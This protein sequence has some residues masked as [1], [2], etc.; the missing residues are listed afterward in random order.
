MLRRL[1]NL[2]PLSQ[3]WD[4]WHE[5]LQSMTDSRRMLPI[6][7][8]RTCDLNLRVCSLSNDPFLIRSAWTVSRRF[9]A[10]ERRQ[11]LWYWLRALFWSRDGENQHQ[12][13]RIFERDIFGTI[14]EIAIRIKSN[15]ISKHPLS[16]LLQFAD[17]KIGPFPEKSQFHWIPTHEKYDWPTSQWQRKIHWRNHSLPL[18]KSSPFAFS[19][20]SDVTVTVPLFNQFDPSESSHWPSKS[21][22]SPFWSLLHCALFAQQTGSLALSALRIDWIEWWRN[23]YRLLT[24]DWNR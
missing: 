13:L 1:P 2:K 14:S 22:Q 9:G 7:G 5:L 12:L 18:F 10:T 21:R 6:I 8:H 24:C 17:V 15:I 19:S 11:P 16:T 4:L 3:I 20:N 23:L